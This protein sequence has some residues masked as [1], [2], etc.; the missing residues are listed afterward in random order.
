M[1]RVLLGFAL[2]WLAARWYYFG[3]VPFG[4]APVYERTGGRGVVGEAIGAARD[5]GEEARVGAKMA[6]A[7][8]EEKVERIR[9]AAEE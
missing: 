5:L 8:F 4:Q 2:G 7:S 3:E 6:R 9:K 1:R